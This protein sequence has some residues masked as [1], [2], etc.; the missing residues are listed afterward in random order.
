[1]AEGPIARKRA[2]PASR[3]KAAAKRPAP[4]P[5]KKPQIPLD[6][7]PETPNFALRLTE[8]LAETE[9]EVA[10]AQDTF[11][12]RLNEALD[13]INAANAGQR[14]ATP[15]EVSTSTAQDPVAKGGFAGWLA[16]LDKLPPIRLPIGPA[17][18][19]RIGLPALAA[20]VV[21]M[22][23]MSRSAASSAEPTG[24][25]LPAQQQYAIQQQAPLFAKPAADASAPASDAGA[26]PAAPA[27]AQPIGVSEST[28]TGGFD[29]MDIGIKLVAVLGLAYGS[30]MLLKRFGPNGGRMSSGAGPD[31]RVISSISLAPNRSVHVLEL[32]GGKTLLV[33]ATPTAVNL[34]AEL[35]A[36]H[37]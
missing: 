30:L 15:T 12:L 35:P 11:A 19:W 8:G 10:P 21:V 26:A 28:A 34:L 18:P 37:E 36:E 32:P 6:D 13:A 4:A 1:L 2:V 16:A 31:V 27:P 22:A 20:L 5:R 29:F 17:I 14:A 25:Q 9:R 23:F 3:P 33:G 24:V 7:E